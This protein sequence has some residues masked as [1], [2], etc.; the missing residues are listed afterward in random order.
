MKF[1]VEIPTC[2]EGVFV[3]VGF[4]GPEDIVRTTL[5]AERLG[6]NAVWATDFLTPTPDYGVPDAKPPNWYEPLISLAFC[7]ARTKTIRLGTGVLLAPLRDPVIL[8]KEVATL[9]QFSNGRFLLGLGLGMCRDEYVAVRPRDRKA[10]R[11]TLMDE[12]IEALRLLLA[13]DTGKVKYTGEYTEFHDVQL[14]PKPVQDPLPIYVPGRTPQALERAARYKLGIMVSA[15]AALERMDALIPIAEKFGCDPARIDVVAE[16][17]LRLAPT[18]EKALQEY[19]TSRQGKFRFELRRT[20][21]E[22]FLSNNW[23]GT[24]AEVCEKINAV[25]A[26]GIKHFNVLHIAGDTV[27]DRLEQ[28]QMFAEEV[29]LKVGN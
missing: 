10:R 20:P 12:C 8:A 24:P 29:M 5:E 22:P 16:G 21:A 15:S 19:Q 11:G 3:P 18:R 25:A 14:D 13:H 23:I 1:D 17:E 2:R 28:M 26:I 4:G 27:N 9:D 6:Y 7:A